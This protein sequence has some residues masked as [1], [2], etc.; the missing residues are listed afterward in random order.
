MAPEFFQ[1]NDYTS[2]YSPEVFTDVIKVELLVCVDAYYSL[3]A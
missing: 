3:S 1:S 2:N